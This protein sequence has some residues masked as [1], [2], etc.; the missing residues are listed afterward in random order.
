MSRQVTPC[1]QERSAL[2]FWVAL[3]WCN[4]HTIGNRSESFSLSPPDSQITFQG[5]CSDLYQFNTTYRVTSC[6]TYYQLSLNLKCMW[7]MGVRCA[8]PWKGIIWFIHKHLS[9]MSSNNMFKKYQ[10]LCLGWDFLLSDVPWCVLYFWSNISQGN[11]NNGQLSLLCSQT[12][13]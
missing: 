6:C 2:A 13:D 4:L 9:I 1:K 7:T 3:R 5:D 11:P 10:V 12:E 8:R